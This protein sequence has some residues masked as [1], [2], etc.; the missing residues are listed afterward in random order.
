MSVSK[1]ALVLSSAVL[2]QYYF[3][4]CGFVPRLSLVTIN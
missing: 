4:I 3:D 1:V 2:S